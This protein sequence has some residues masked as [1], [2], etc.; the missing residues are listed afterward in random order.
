MLSHEA[1][2]FPSYLYRPSFFPSNPS[3]SP[4]IISLLSTP[5]L[6]SFPSRQ[7]HTGIRVT[8]VISIPDRRIEGNENLLQ[9]RYNND[10]IW[11]NGESEGNVRITSEPCVERKYING[12]EPSAH[13]T[14]SLPTESPP[15]AG[16]C[17][18]CLPGIERREG[19]F[20]RGISECI[21]R[22]S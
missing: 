3:N 6:T 22:V 18:G 11:G 10:P 9:P 19:D 1:D 5:S 15:W 7:N 4:I 16:R 8:A 21:P 2:K 12:G 17:H 14:R 13:G 20:P